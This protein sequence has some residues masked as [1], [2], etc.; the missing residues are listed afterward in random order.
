[1]PKMFESYHVVVQDNNSV[2][3]IPLNKLEVLLQITF[4]LRVLRK[5][6]VYRTNIVVNNVEVRKKI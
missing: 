5:Y 4:S 6:I 3:Q 2:L 1:M